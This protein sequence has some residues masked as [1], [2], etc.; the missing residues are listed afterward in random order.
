MKI[1]K[2]IK[3]PSWGFPLVVTIAVAP[4]VGAATVKTTINFSVEG[5][6]VTAASTLF[7]P[8]GGLSTT[9]NQSGG[10]SVLALKDITGAT[11]TVNLTVAVSSSY[12]VD[13]WG[14][15]GPLGL[16]KYSSRDFNTNTAPNTPTPGSPT[17]F[18]T[19]TLSGLT[20]GDTYK[21]WIASGRPDA[22]VSGAWS[23][24]NTTST[25]GSQTINNGAL[26]NPGANW[27][28]GNNFV[29]FNQVVVDSSGNLVMTGVSSG[30]SRLPFS[31][32]QIAPVP[33]PT[34]AMMGGLGL[35]AILRR[36]RG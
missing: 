22:T 2:P 31:G 9:W 6:P 7:G 10:A 15:S 28:Q 29:L 18:L 20:V 17:N 3:V 13:D 24:T 11:T 35:L 5:S 26:N 4:L 1:N 14:A 16:L 30:G 36:R 33:E 8:N 19:M 34:T 23:T 32:F 27:V 25:V 12:G 21:V